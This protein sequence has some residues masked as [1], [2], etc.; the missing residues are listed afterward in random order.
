MKSPLV[1][2]IVILWTLAVASTCVAEEMDTFS[3][4]G[5]PI[6]EES[7]A[8]AARGA[9]QFFARLQDKGPWENLGAREIFGN[10]LLLAEL[11]QDLDALDRAFEV[12]ESMQDLKADSPTFGNFRWYWFNQAVGDKNAVEFSMQ[13]GGLLYRFHRDRLSPAARERL[14]RMMRNSV[15]G[16]LSHGVNESY[17]NIFIMKTWNLIS[18]GEWLN[19]PEIAEQGYDHLDRFVVYTA[20]NGISEYISP[21]YYG[22]DLDSLGL[23]ARYAGRERA[24]G[25]AKALLDLFWHDIALNWYEPAARLGGAHSR[26]YNYLFGR[27]YL[28]QHL[29]ANGWLP[30]PEKAPVG[31]MMLALLGKCPP[32]PKM[33]ELS[34]TRFPR[35]IRQSWRES[36]HETATNYLARRFALGSAGST[37]GTMDKPLVV[38]FADP[39][40][41]G[42]YYLMDARHDPFGKSKIPEGTGG[43]K[44]ALHL[45]PFLTT[46]QDREEVLL[47]A[48]PATDRYTPESDYLASHLVLPSEVE[49]CF[50]GD[51]A[52]DT[53]KEF[54][55]PVAMGEPMFL[56]HAG[57]ILGVKV[58]A[59]RTLDGAE[60]KVEM[61]C[62]SV[63]DKAMRLTVIHHAGA[64]RKVEAGQAMVVL[65]VRMAEGGDLD[66]FRRQFAS[67][68]GAAQESNGVVCAS[69][70]GL[71]AELGI[72]ADVRNQR[73]IHATL[74]G[75]RPP[76]SLLAVDGNDIGKAMIEAVPPAPD[77]RKRLEAAEVVLEPGQCRAIEAESAFQIVKPME[78]ASDPSA[79]GGKFIWMSGEPG[80]EGG[81]AV[82]RATWP[83]EVKKAGVYYL[84]GRVLTPTPNDDSFF[85]GAQSEEG[86][87]LPR[88]DWHT[89][90]HTQWTWVPVAPR[91]MPAD[92]LRLPAGR[93]RLRF[94]VRED[95]ARLDALF[96]SDRPDAAPEGA[97]VPGAVK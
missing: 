82:A 56:A 24:R 42:G 48:A 79:S 72:E 74:D 6:S 46:I 52:I 47:F 13:A 1:R 57:A 85:V 10:A 50:I 8:A 55:A 4:Q 69:A 9:Q 94:S 59:G 78:I 71:H 90:V 14:E 81:S 53:R 16:I 84:W 31:G 37:Y 64:T 89:G 87:V 28:D 11:K 62:D 21:T 83:I 32:D 96:I 36:P 76:K 5:K 33:R 39:T 75:R 58:L 44:K 86:E 63:K 65:W 49:Q 66:A 80:K 17:T 23:I 25:Q 95:G 61:V 97:S 51:K 35:L 40:L 27:G 54:S 20:E 19:L 70:T 88:A 34:L 92:W 29:I 60:A 3:I 77:A 12:A 26:D 67:A 30:L 45:T 15:K 38:L 43:H 93:V 41:V 7:L 18:L 2:T 68:K 73:R 91:D 22:T